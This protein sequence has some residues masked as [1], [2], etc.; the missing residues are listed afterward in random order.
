MEAAGLLGQGVS[1]SEVARRLGVHRQSVIRWARQLAQAGRAGLK[2]AGR[3][4]RKPRLSPTQ[5]RQLEQELKRGPRAFGYGTGRWTASQVRQLIVFRT[6][7]RY[8]PAHVWRLLRQLGRS[9]QRPAGK[10]LERAEATLPYRKRMRFVV[11]YCKDLNATEAAA[12]AGYSPRTAAS[13]GQR[14]L[15]SP[16]VG[17]AIAEARTRLLKGSETTVERILKEMAALAFA[18]PGESLDKHGLPLPVDKLPEGVGRAQ[19]VTVKRFFRYERGKQRY[20]GR[21][22]TVKFTGKL[23]ALM[24]LGKHLNMFAQNR[25]QAKPSKPVEPRGLSMESVIGQTARESVTR[26]PEPWDSIITPDPPEPVEKSSSRTGQRGRSS[27]RREPWARIITQPDPPR[28]GGKPPSRTGQRG[29]GSFRREL[30][31]VEYLKD[32]NA[33]RA[34]IRAGYSPKTAA[35][36]GQR[37]LKPPAVTRLLAEAHSRLFDKVEVSVERVRGEF[38]AIADADIGQF[39]DRRGRLRPIN[40]V[41]EEARRALSELEFEERYDRTKRKHIRARWELKLLSKGAA[42]DALAKHAIL[43]EQDKPRPIPQSVID[44]LVRAAEEAKAAKAQQAERRAN[45]EGEVSSPAEMA[46]SSSR[47]N[48]DERGGLGI[49]SKEKARQ[50]DI[51]SPHQ[52]EPLKSAMGKPPQANRITLVRDSPPHSL[53]GRQSTA[54]PHPMWGFVDLGDDEEEDKPKGR[55]PPGGGAI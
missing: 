4:G 14:L 48:G 54:P 49:E 30:F 53:A 24:V 31:A 37:L 44:E 35:S 8:H 23:A 21:R 2:K 45:S 46:G 17:S 28:P 36:Q 19:S 11:E 10:P 1:Q 3:A 26:Q 52:A 41:P 9:R 20:V 47:P 40:Q 32:F 38:L 27:F 6:G 34:A 43:L 25:K 22:V 18:D 7:V 16:V 5:L 12:R 29:R 42:L 50:G 13:Q 51:P 39:F 33:T 55:W 15:K